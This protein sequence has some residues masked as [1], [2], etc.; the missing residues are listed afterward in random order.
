MD[1]LE[2]LSGSVAQVALLVQ[3]LR[4]ERSE[5][6]ARLAKAAT[7]RQEAVREAV[8]DAEAAK[9]EAERLRLE[10]E[11]T[12]T[13]EKRAQQ[14]ELEAAHLA[15][16]LDQ[17]RRRHFNEKG[18]L[19]ERLATL[20]A[21]LAAA[22]Q[23]DEILPA[24]NLELET[25]RREL[26]EQRRALEALAAEADAARQDLAKARARADAAQESGERQL[27][28]IAALEVERKRLETSL[29]GYRQ[30]AESEAGLRARLA[31][32]ESEAAAL[33]EQAKE[34]GLLRESAAR[35][36]AE[37]ADLRRQ[38]RELAGLDK[39]RKLMVR[40]LQEVYATLSSLRLGAS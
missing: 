19:E 3:G 35:L 10:Q 31:D 36:E 6:A 26:E 1:S 38:K 21:Q 30:Q 29:D 16:E 11:A 28:E 18:A 4:R 34:L 13:L 33:K 24:T 27:E 37:K 7:E 9:A 15:Q 14:A 32:L 40:R 22:R 12:P 17:E 5:L 23:V 8:Q 2:R 39:E 25:K 20:E